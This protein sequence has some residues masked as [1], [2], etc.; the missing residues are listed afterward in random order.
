MHNY[1]VYEGKFICHFCKAEVRSL[2]L[3]SEQQKMTWL[4]YKKHLSEVNLNTR[5]TRKDYE[6]KI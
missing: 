2:R 4:C 5:K 1:S 6:R 3:Y